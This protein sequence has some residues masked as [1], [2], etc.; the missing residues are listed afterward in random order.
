MEFPPLCWV[1][2]RY[3]FPS[4]LVLEACC[5]DTETHGLSLGLREDGTVHTSFVCKLPTWGTPEL[6]SS[7]LPTPNRWSQWT[8]RRA[9][10][11]QPHCLMFTM[12]VHMSGRREKILLLNAESQGQRTALQKDVCKIAKRKGQEAAE[13]KD[14]YVETD[15]E[16]EHCH[17]LS[18]PHIGSGDGPE[19]GQDL[20]VPYSSLMV[21]PVSHSRLTDSRLVGFAESQR[22]SGR[23]WDKMQHP[24]ITVLLRILTDLESQPWRGEIMT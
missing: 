13:I 24:K 1:T 8:L 20:E 22:V 2:C 16:D 17:W 21:E 12:C 15:W 23:E 19:F 10:W 7:A 6:S 4:A 3:I 18:W 5:L 9:P 11:W 14:I